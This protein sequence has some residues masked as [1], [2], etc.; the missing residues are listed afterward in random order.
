M[1]PSPKNWPGSKIATT[2]SLPCS[3][4]TVSLPCLFECK[5]QCRRHRLART[6]ADSYGIPIPAFPRPLWRESLSNMFLSGFSTGASFGS[7]NF[8][9][10][11][12]RTAAAP[13]VFVPNLEEVPDRSL[14][15][16]NRVVIAHRPNLWGPRG[17]SRY[18]ILA[19]L[20]LRP[21][22]RVAVVA[23]IAGSLTSSGKT[24]LKDR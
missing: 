3:D 12:R 13:V 16:G 5:T 17:R 2:A 20:R 10:L 18:L 8:R 19:R 6:R 9:T 21:T 1:Q 11:A 23:P 4:R 14:I 24:S 22:R 15:L 7:T